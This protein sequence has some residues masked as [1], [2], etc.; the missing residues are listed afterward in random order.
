M[1]KDR[2]S[3]FKKSNYSDKFKYGIDPLFEKN[4]SFIKRVELSIKERKRL[5]VLL[6]LKISDY[7]TDFIKSIIS[8]NKSMTLA[9]LNVIRKLEETIKQ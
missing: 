9:Q 4:K 8:S 3:K 1:A 6:K 5:K 2:F 7:Y